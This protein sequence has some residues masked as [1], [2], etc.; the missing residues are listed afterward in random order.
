MRQRSRWLTP[1]FK[2]IHE[3]LRWLVVFALL[4]TISMHFFGVKFEELSPLLTLC[5]MSFLVMTKIHGNT[6]IFSDCLEFDGKRF[7][8]D[9]TLDLWYFG[10][11]PY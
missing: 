3:N 5:S 9:P 7:A 11:L 2:S 10:N 4:A 8:Y 6:P 1:A